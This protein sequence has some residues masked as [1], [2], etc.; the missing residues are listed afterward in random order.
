[1]ARGRSALADGAIKGRT[2]RLDDAGDA[3][4]TAQRGAGLVRA[5][6][7]AEGVLEIAER[8]IG[9]GIIAQGRAAGRH[10]LGQDGADDH[11]EALGL[12]RGDAR[13]GSRRQQ[14]RAV[15]RLADIDIAE[16]GDQPLI[17]QR[18]LEWR[19][20][21]G[22]A[23]CD[24]R[25]VERIAERLDAEIAKQRMRLKPVAADQR[26]E[27]KAADVIIGHAGAAREV[28][29]HVIMRGVARDLVMERARPMRLGGVQ[30]GKA[31]RHAEMHH[32][33]V[34]AL[35]IGE[36]IFGAAAEGENPAA[37]QPRREILGE[38]ETQ[39][40]AALLDACEACPGHHGF[41]PA[42]NGF[43]LGQFGHGQTPADRARRLI[44]S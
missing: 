16:P 23:L 25:A 29:D 11:G 32:E 28:E 17:E 13:G 15:E 7:G 27:A 20:F 35:K 12:G 21:T 14:A 26:H 1:M 30:D 18:G 24:Q 9:P 3:A 44:A 41:E 34:V 38:R 39:I 10:R 19:F 43:N 8:A 6:I 4:G 31:S 22:E 37:G 33:H 36:K 5:A 40:G 42:A 2:A